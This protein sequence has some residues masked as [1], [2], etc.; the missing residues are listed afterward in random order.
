MAY[1][2]NNSLGNKLN[3][4]YDLLSDAEASWPLGHNAEAKIALGQT[5]T[6]A[7]QFSGDY[8]VLLPTLYQ[9]KS[10]IALSEREFPEA[11]ANGKQALALVGT[12]A[13]YPGIE[14]KRAL[15]LA[16]VHSGAREEGKRSS[17]EAL[18]MARQNGSQRL[19]SNTLLALAEALLESGDAQGALENA[20]QAQESC[21]PAGQL[22]SEWRAWLVMARA[23]Q[24][25]NL[26]AQANEYAK[27]ARDV[28]SRLQQKWGDDDFKAYV[29]RK[30]VRFYLKQLDELTA[31]NQPEQFPPTN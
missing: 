3:S 20:R 8:K 18:E 19:L 14:A 2:I 10:L 25:L 24:K 7:N 9:I 15:G 1:S 23:S 29:A 4:A 28:L 27:S 16:Q 6:I 13:I 21:A 22:E 30:D 11:A 31:T 12:E 5:S 17:Q 26:T